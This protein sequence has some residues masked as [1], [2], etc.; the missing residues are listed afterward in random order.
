M[1]FSRAVATE[2]RLTVEFRSRD[3]LDGDDLLIGGRSNDKLIGGA[4]ADVFKFN[5]RSGDDRI[6]D[7]DPT[8]DTL[9]LKGVRKTQVDL[10]ETKKG[11]LVDWGKGSVLLLKL[12]DNDIDRSDLLFG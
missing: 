2:T 6:T 4:G 12:D 8:E 11:V 9:R 7:F 1:T 10:I 5:R 3:S